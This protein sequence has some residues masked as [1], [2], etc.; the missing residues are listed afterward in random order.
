MPTPLQQIGTAEVLVALATLLVV[1]GILALLGYLFY[2]GIVDPPEAGVTADGSR[3]TALTPEMR[4][5][6][7]WVLA[8]LLVLVG[9]GGVVLGAFLT[10]LADREYIRELVRDDVLQSDV[11]SNDALVDTT[12]AVLV[13]GGIGIA[14]T[15]VV[16]VLGGIAVAAYRRRFDAHET[17][18]QDQRPSM[19]ANALLGAVIAVVASFIPF[20]PVV[21]GAATGYLE[22][23]DSWTG[24]RAGIVTGLFLAIPSTIFLSVLAIG[25]VVEGWGI[26]A[27][28]VVLGILISLA[29]SV[30]MTA[31]GGFAGGYIVQSERGSS[32]QGGTQPPGEEPP[33]RERDN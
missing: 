24:V 17:D 29:I 25:L 27:L 33:A 19:A 11:L 14:V 32:P 15:G 8:L 23:A 28:V 13:W 16:I 5:T 12:E 30:G 21:G 1:V 10:T 6:V 7:D 2:R 4:R 31:I 20:S 26:A 9:L 3:A 18:G 22:Q